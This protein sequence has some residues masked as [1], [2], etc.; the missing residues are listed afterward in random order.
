M[1]EELRDIFKTIFDLKDN[2]IIENLNA[3]E[4][5]PWDSMTHLMIITEIEQV[6]DIIFEEDSVPEL[7]TFKKLEHETLKLIEV[8]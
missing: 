7:N 6:F 2:E 5:E 4:Y 8:K 3:A 1:I